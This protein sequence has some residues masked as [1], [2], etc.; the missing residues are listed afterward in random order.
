[1]NKTNKKNLG[2]SLLECLLAIT[3][4]ASITMMAV[5]YYMI[6]LRSMHVSQ[7]IAQVNR[8]TGAS[9]EWLRLQNQT[10]FSGEDTGEAISI[11]LLLNA[12]L[13]HL[14]TDTIDPWGGNITITPGLTDTSYVA[15][16]L[17]NIPQKDCLNLT[18][19]LQYINHNQTA[20][21]CT[22]PASNQFT[23]EF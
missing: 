4:I 6:T 9:Y 23:G 13:I 2:I 22:D 12:E 18:Q 3:L 20:N 1:M 16:T 21:S 14:N 5:R 8:L 11:Q 17:P 19:Q 7:A 10:D 15:I